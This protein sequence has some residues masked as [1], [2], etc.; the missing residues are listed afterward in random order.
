MS[1]VRPAAVAGAF[2]PDDPQVIL[3]AFSH[4]MPERSETSVL[5]KPIPRALIV[6]H[7]GYIYSG[8]AAAKGYQLWRDAASQI[9]TIVVM[10]P[11][12]RVPFE[13]ITTIS[14]DEVETPLGNLQVD[15]ELRD[16]ILSDCPQVGISDIANAPEHSL[17]VHF[18]FIKNVLPDAK[19]LPLLN[20]QVSAHDVMAVMQRLWRE[21][22]VYFV[23]SS[24]L[25]HFHT[26]GDAQRID[27]ETA[28]AIRHGNWQVLNGEMACGYKGIQG[29]LGIMY[30]HPMMI[31]QLGLINSGDTAGSKDRVVG[32][33]TWAVYELQ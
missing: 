29:L 21:E 8:E 33:G 16:V 32:Y 22:G 9:K 5:E 4:W 28:E 18:P 20:G 15:T 3:S 26:Y 19:V 13:G 10:G 1:N 14:V 30:E 25:S 12:H 27:G 31:E 23:I 17:E 11:A 24:D 6:P 7:A 2:Y